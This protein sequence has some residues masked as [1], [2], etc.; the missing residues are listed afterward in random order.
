MAEFGI[1]FDTWQD[2]VAQVILGLREDGMFAATVGGIT[3][4][5]PRQVAKTFIVMVLILALCTLYPNM[6]VLWTAHRT[7]TATNTFQKMKAMALRPAA[8]VYL[9][10]GSNQ[11]TGI[12]DANGEQEIPFK[13]G[14]RVLFGARE[15]G[16][17]RGFDEVDVEVFDEAQILSI[18]ALED[19]VA[20]TNQSRFP[21]GA[22]LF[23]MNTPPRPN[24]PGEMILARRAEALAHKQGLPD[25]GEPVAAGDALY[26]E[27]SADS[28]VGKPGGPS[29][30]DPRQVELANPSYPHRTPPVAVARL[31]KNMPDDASWRREGLGVYDDA[32][33]DPSVI[34]REQWSALGVDSPPVEGIDSYGVKFSPDGALVALSAA[35]KAADVVHVELIERRSMGGGT[36][37]LVDWL[38]GGESPR[39]R[40]AAQI[41]VDGKAHAG[42]LV[43]ALRAAGVPAQVILTPTTDQVTTA[44]SMLLDAVTEKSLT[45]LDHPG[46]ATLVD[47]V[48]SSGRREIGKNGGWGFR[49]LGDGECTSAESAV[50]AH[51]GAKT[52]KRRPGRKQKAVVMT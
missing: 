16:F 1:E 42:N 12:R 51:W 18:R 50:M 10:P 48:A 14:S 13:N 6:T 15:A 46:Q 30:D 47:S 29:L 28:D 20:A 21:F 2:G 52:S 33:L 44:H 43:N 26:V 39:W 38:A 27:C 31:R 37:W 24:D 45:N 35:R 22:L 4:S 19:M 8:R 32:V 34:S 5:I 11:G 23:Y 17:G 36:G 3:L 25:F 41:V 9:K 40:K 7:R 49:P